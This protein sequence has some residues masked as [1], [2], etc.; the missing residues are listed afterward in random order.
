MAAG[1]KPERLGMSLAGAVRPRRVRV[2][3]AGQQRLGPC[4]CRRGG[5]GVEL[6]G[7]GLPPSGAAVQPASLGEQRLGACSATCR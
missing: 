1:A 5:A 7:A 3:G 4:D 2:P 6:L